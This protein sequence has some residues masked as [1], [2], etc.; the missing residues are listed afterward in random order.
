MNK[1]ALSVIAGALL[2]TGSA[3]AQT[4]TQ[5]GSNQA[6]SAQTPQTLQTT[7]APLV[8]KA[9]QPTRQSLLTDDGTPLKVNPQSKNARAK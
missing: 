8:R 4:S 1:L 9:Q 3:V 7:P 2:A 6:P 5:T